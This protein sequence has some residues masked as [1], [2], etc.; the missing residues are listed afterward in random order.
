MEKYIVKI[1][2]GYDKQS[3]LDLPGIIVDEMTFSATRFVA[4]YTIEQA[5]TVRSHE[6]VKR[7]FKPQDQQEPTDDGVARTKVYSYKRS[8]LEL[9]R[10]RDKSIDGT[11]IY[12]NF[13]KDVFVGD[14]WGMRRHTRPSNDTV[15]NVLVQNADYNYS[16]DGTGVDVILNIASALDLTD[17]DFFDDNG[18]TRIQQFQWNTLP[19]MSAL[20]TVDYNQS[21]TLMTT[22]MAPY[23]ETPLFTPAGHYDL[24]TSYFTINNHGY[25]T[26]DKVLLTLNDLGTQW[27]RNTYKYALRIDD[28]I[29]RFI[30][31][32]AFALEWDE[33]WYENNSA[34]GNVN[35]DIVFANN[36]YEISGRMREVDATTGLTG[37]SATG[38]QV[39]DE[40]GYTI[41]VQEFDT[42]TFD[43]TGTTGH[44]MYIK[45]ALGTGTQNAIPD[46]N[47]E[48]ADM[49]NNGSATQITFKPK[50]PG[51]YYYQ[52]ANDPNVNG[53]IHVYAAYFHTVRLENADA[54][55][56]DNIRLRRTT[57]FAAQSGVDKHALQVADYSVGHTHGFGTG[58]NIYIWPRNQM[59]IFDR[60]N[61]LSSSALYSHG[62][63]A[64]RIFHE[65]KGNSRP[66]VLISS[67]SN[68][69]GPTTSIPPDAL[70]FRNEILKE[71]GIGDTGQG[72]KGNQASYGTVGTHMQ[73]G[74]PVSEITDLA[75]QGYMQKNEFNLPIDIEASNT[76]F[77]EAISPESNLMYDTNGHDEYK[78]M[79]DAGVISVASAGNQTWKLAMPDDPDFNNGYLQFNTTAGKLLSFQ[80]LHRG[81][82]FKEGDAIIVGGLGTDFTRSPEIYQGQET[83]SAT[84]NKGSRVDCVAA[85]EFLHHVSSLYGSSLITGTSFSTP[86][87]GGF[88][89]CVLEKYPNT[90]P[91]QMRKYVRE[92]AISSETLFN[93]STDPLA[94][95]KAGDPQYF[96]S[97]SCMGYSGNILYF[98][99]SLG[100]DPTTL[101]NSPIVYTTTL[102]NNKLDFTTSQINTK[103]NSI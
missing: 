79:L 95:S 66:T 50:K 69:T 100:F 76:Q 48:I 4:N 98:D 90:T 13:T 65:T 43:T 32:A 102:K 29:V 23:V 96:R 44:P 3:I 55:S 89:A 72:V 61:Y 9:I 47:S 99:P 58:A 51:I 34:T 56:T 37:A 8:S 26:G 36:E 53:E 63:D 1:K 60:T 84:S 67:M 24:I 41:T 16:Y 94:P 5:N 80:A 17:S 97:D 62:W 77:L 86:I 87:V 19:G 12:D 54:T 35:L 46:G 18:N 49:S 64:F 14:N 74:M 31:A 52:S 15:Q 10:D 27:L 68:K 85:G 38:N 28:N 59:K 75:F 93:V 101:S 88:I 70:V 22:P 30:D 33:G 11:N 82:V 71:V 78:D 103:L 20:P 57:S 81:D 45:T 25:L 73:F 21:G 6:G 91:R 40:P 92:H 42:I 7:I 83:F 39:S 2:R